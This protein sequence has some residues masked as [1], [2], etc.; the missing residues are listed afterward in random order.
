MICKECQFTNSC[1]AEN[2]ERIECTPYAESCKEEYEYYLT[3]IKYLQ[4]KFGKD[5]EEF[6]ARADIYIDCLEY[7]AIDIYYGPR[8][9]IKFDDN[10]LPF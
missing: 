5:T 9:E 3:Q 10:N 1:Y 2:S 6:E 7:L 4:K 8:P